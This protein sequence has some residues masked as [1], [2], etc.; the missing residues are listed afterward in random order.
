[1]TG[2]SV[3]KIFII[4]L[5]GLFFTIFL[6]VACDSVGFSLNK[7]CETDR[8]Y[9]LQLNAGIPIILAIFAFGYVFS[10]RDL[11]NFTPV[12]K[13]LLRAILIIGLIAI[14]ISVWVFVAG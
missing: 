7:L 9:A 10:R 3:L 11:Q 5:I 1:M 12:Q 14:L 13:G 6:V 8:L 4:L 2:Q